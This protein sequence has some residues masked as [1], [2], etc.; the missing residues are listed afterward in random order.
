MTFQLFFCKTLTV[1]VTIKGP[2]KL[3]KGHTS[4]IKDCENDLLTTFH[5]S[6]GVICFMRN[7]PTYSLNWKTHAAYCTFQSPSLS[8]CFSLFQVPIFIP[9][10]FS[11]TCFFMVFLSL[12]SDP[13][14]TGIG[15][16]ISL[17]GIP[18]YYIFIHCERKPKWFQ[19][20]SGQR[21]QK[22]QMAKA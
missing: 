18:A 7:R 14:N 2:F 20:L 16:A 19:K 4:T 22:M 17:T 13:I 21:L 8:L 15:F 3:Q 9:A 5:K 6:F 11:F 12:Y 10:V 1:Q